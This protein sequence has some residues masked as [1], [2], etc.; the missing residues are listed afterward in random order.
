MGGILGLTLSFL[1]EY[2]NPVMLPRGLVQLPVYLRVRLLAEVRSQ[3][4]GFPE[5]PP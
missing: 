5:L 4:L 2:P 1:A 3:L